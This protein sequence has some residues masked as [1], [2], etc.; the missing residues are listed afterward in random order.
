MSAVPFTESDPFS[1]IRY[2]YSLKEMLYSHKGPFGEIAIADHEYF[3]RMLIL[4]G[5]VQLTERDEHYYHEM[6]AHVPLFTHPKPEDI[7]IIGGGDG[8]TLREVLKHDTVRLATLAEIDGGVIEVAQRFLPTLASGFSDP[9]AHVEITDGA[10]HVATMRDA[11]D[12]ILVD[13]TDPVGPALSL[14]SEK[15]FADA[16]AALRAGGI[17]VA[18]TESLHFHLDFVR[19]VQSKLGRHFAFADVYT[20]PIATYAG[21]WWTFSIGSKSTNPRKAGF[22]RSRSMPAKYY[23]PDVHKGAFLPPSLCRRLLLDGQ[24]SPPAH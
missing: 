1:P 12:I 8:G 23:A 18:Q 13:C 16:C 9:R 3:G 22:R 21:N 19:D 14:F 20:V 6:L 4:D 17:F 24:Q 10:K 15:F 5:V 11:Y 2:G 7:L